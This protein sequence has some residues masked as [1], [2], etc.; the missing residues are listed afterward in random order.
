DS[1]LPRF[2]CRNE[3]TKFSEGSPPNLSR[4]WDEMKKTFLYMLALCLLATP[5]FAQVS[6]SNITGTAADATT[7]VLP[8]LTV[9]ATNNGT[10]VA[11][12]SVTNEAGVYTIL[13]IIPGTYTVSAELPGF[14]KE[15]YNMVGLT[16]GVTV[17][18]NFTMQVAN[19]AQNVE[20]T[21]AADTLIAAT[22]Q[23]V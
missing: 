19:Q 1:I 21:V 8:G 15:T 6:N 7:A 13:S 5:A 4:R 3:T 22:S 18:L 16:N 12:S 14:R 23:T 9:T 11:V 17:R 2:V 10:G 20:V